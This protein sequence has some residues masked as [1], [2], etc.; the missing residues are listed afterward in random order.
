MDKVIIVLGLFAF[1][2]QAPKLISDVIGIDSGNMKLG[3]GGKL[4]GSGFLGNMIASGVGGAVG[5]FT[6]GLGGAW[7]S[8]LNGAG[9]GVGFLNGAFNGWKGKGMQFNKQ[10]QAVY[11]DVFEQKGKAGF[12]GG[13]AFLDKK[14]DDSKK[15]VQK[16]YQKGQ[17]AY[18]EKQENKKEFQQAYDKAYKNQETKNNEMYTKLRDEFLEAQAKFEENRINQISE[19]QRQY[20]EKQQ[21]FEEEKNKRVK[22]LSMNYE[23]ARNSSNV[24]EMANIQK[25]LNEAK[26]SVYSDITLEGKIKDLQIAKFGMTEDGKRLQMQMQEALAINEEAIMEQARIDYRKANPKYKAAHTYVLEKKAEEEAKKWREEHALENAKNVAMYEEAF[27][28]A[29]QAPGNIGGPG[30]G[31]P[32]PLGTPK[33]PGDSKK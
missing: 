4:R 9:A 18:Q 21:A 33:E 29:N 31:N 11:S 27:K 32:K 19:Y 28:R 24:V 10:R 7:T 25:Q 14:K 2:K 23:K 6:G 16:S 26:A 8:K 3:I 17:E 5:A 12:F 30:L 1:A 20:T 22:K 15:S 13:R